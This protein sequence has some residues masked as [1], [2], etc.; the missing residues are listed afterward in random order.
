MNKGAKRMDKNIKK[1]DL[2]LF[3]SNR[4]NSFIDFKNF[5]QDFSELY[6]TRAIYLNIRDLNT[7]FNKNIKIINKDLKFIEYSFR[8]VHEKGSIKSENPDFW[9]GNKKY[10]DKI[11]NYIKLSSKLK[12]NDN[13]DGKIIM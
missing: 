2:V 10:W 9:L 4:N 1:S 13:I 6:N 11:M 12:Q 3:I 5:L 8:D 7:K